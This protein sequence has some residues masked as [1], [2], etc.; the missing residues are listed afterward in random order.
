MNC[1]SQ[2]LLCVL[3]L[4]ASNTPY[5]QVSSG[6]LSIP[7]TTTAINSSSPLSQRVVHYEIDAK[8]DAKTHALDATEIL[9]YHNLT[10]QVQDTFPFH[11]Y[12]N[13]FQPSATWMR[14]A[15]RD[16][17]AEEFVENW[18]P[19]NRGAEE[20]KK[21]EVADQGD[22]TSQLQFVHP[23]D[24]NKDDKTVV[25][26]RLP[27]PIPPDGYVQF[28]IKWH[29]QFP[30]TVARTGWDRDAVLGAQWFPKVGVW[31][32]GAWNCHQFHAYTEFFADF[33][34]YDVKLT[35]PQN[36]VVGASGLEVSNVNNPDGTKTVSF[37]ADDIHDF[38]W[39]A[40]PHYR[41]YFDTFQSSMGP[42][43]IRIM[44]QPSHWGQAARH[45]R[46]VK[47]TMDRFERWYGPYP[48]KTL[49]VV[50]PERG[51]A[52]GG[53]EYPTFITG[54][55]RWFQPEGWHLDTDAAVE[56][57]FGHQYWYGMVATNE[58]EDPWMDEGINQ[59]TES[60][61]MD[62]MFG[63]STSLLNIWGLTGGEVEGD[64]YFLRG[65][66]DLDPIVRNGWQYANWNSYGAIAYGKTA[67]VLRTLESV[68]GEDVMQ[69]AMHTYFMRYRFTHPTKEDFLKT[70]EEVS[71]KNLRWYFDQAVYGTEVLDYEVLK[72]S[73]YPADWY[74][75]NVEEKKGRTE[76]VSNVWIHRKE[77]FVIPI[78]VEI[79]FDNGEKLRE[80][81]DGQDRWVRYEYQKQAKVTSVEIDPDHRYLFDRNNFNNSYLAEAN[82]AATRKLANYWVFLSQFF[83]QFLA[84]WLV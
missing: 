79:K 32:H 34:V 44:L 38:A 1:K 75:E 21:F 6:V 56:H 69:Q 22:L 37:H 9:T 51:S 68:I 43:K 46:V 78:D 62:S 63:S 64:R 41:D 28:K 17:A 7:A 66:E 58:F 15:R 42:V 39:T 20:I 60:K 65:G 26:V 24:D 31:W 52:S 5:A 73:S 67:L 29:D 25:Q 70:I 74:K 71:G 2:L 8:Y 13:G 27:K 35:V 81:W 84:W 76:Y 61:V 48:Y 36:Q 49:T 14:E 47:G 83:A 54:E 12:L 82:G 10:G 11:L 33:G 80:H 77:D 59:Y 23:D 30:K 55:A 3:W 18:E 57:E 45:V 50:D 40:S 16:P 19:R 4:A 53:M 72:V